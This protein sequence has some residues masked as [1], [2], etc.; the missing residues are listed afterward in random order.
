MRIA[1]RIE[2]GIASFPGLRR[3]AIVD[4]DALSEPERN[5]MC[6]LV[7][8]ARVFTTSA[9]PA[10][11]P[12]PDART[13]TLEIEDGTRRRL[14]RVCEPVHDPAIAALLAKVREH[15]ARATLPAPPV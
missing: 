14:L 5:E 2:G 1:L 12:P 9:V 15:V 8:A 4:T 7:D 13:Y 10:A 11:T 6:A 3:P